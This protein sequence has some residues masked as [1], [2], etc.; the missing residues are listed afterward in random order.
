M[1][2]SLTQSASA[3]IGLPADRST[4]TSVGMVKGLSLTLCVVVAVRLMVFAAGVGSVALADPAEFDLRY[5]SGQPWIAFDAMH[6]ALITQEG[7]PTEGLPPYIAFFPLL[8]MMARALLGM[9]PVETALL[10]IAHVS[11]LAGFAFFYA[12]CRQ[13][14]NHAIAMAGCL[15]LVTFPAAAFFSAGMTEGPFF[16]CVA[17]VLYF[18][19]RGNLWTAAVVCGIATAL[20]PTGV[21][22]S[23]VVIFWSIPQSLAASTLARWAA[24][25]ILSVSGIALYQA[26]LWQTYDRFDAYFAA[27]SYWEPGGL[28]TPADEIVLAEIAA[29]QAAEVRDARFYLR[30]TITPQAWNRGLMLVVLGLTV[31]GLVRPGPIPRVMFMLPLVIFLMAYLPGW[32]TR[33]SSVVR[34]QTAALPCFILGALILA[35]WDRPRMVGTLLGA[36]L[37]AQLYYACLFSR[38]IWIG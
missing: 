17:A 35:R 1:T 20:R 18:L 19:Q 22:L 10:L 5:T 27:Q 3:A 28:K 2:C 36:Q 7:Y 30:K 21:A 15:L 34:F 6:Y 4:D 11:T 23:L 37:A 29:R 24:I 32:G 8:P 13:L 38:G 33:A 31:Y 9:I 12:W 16:C 14:T 26:Y 25:S